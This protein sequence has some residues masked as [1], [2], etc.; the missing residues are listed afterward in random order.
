[1]WNL[2]SK[3]LF[4]HNVV[5]FTAVDQKIDSWFSMAGVEKK[6]SLITGQKELCCSK[7]VKDLVDFCTIRYQK[8]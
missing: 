5:I 3:D 6:K 8:G 1:M 2:L 4:S 7:S